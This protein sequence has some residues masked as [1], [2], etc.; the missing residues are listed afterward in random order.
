MVWFGKSCRIVYQQTR[1]LH[2]MI[3]GNAS[4]KEQS[5]TDLLT[6]QGN[7]KTRA[8]YKKTQSSI[9]LFPFGQEVLQEFTMLYLT[10]FVLGAK[11]E[12]KN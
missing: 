2:K 10:H 9:C 12:G 5:G 3:S 1:P 8:R 11:S 6:R 4:I 7:D